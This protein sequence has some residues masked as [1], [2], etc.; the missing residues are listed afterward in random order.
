LKRLAA[1]IYSY[2]VSRPIT[3]LNFTTTCTTEFAAYNL[4]RPKSG[5]ETQDAS[6]PREYIGGEAA[7]LD[8]SKQI[9][10]K[11]YA[12][13]AEVF[14]GGRGWGWAGSLYLILVA[15]TTKYRVCYSIEKTLLEK[16]EYSAVYT[17][18]ASKPPSGT[19]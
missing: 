5:P 16:V 2:S 3:Y 1:R 18:A 14:S 9:T 4:A 8:T 11:E 10:E 12:S 6:K 19:G 17:Y 7:Q 13:V 15:D